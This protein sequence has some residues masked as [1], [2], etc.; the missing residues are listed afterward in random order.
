M[1]CHFQPRDKRSKWPISANLS[2]FERTKKLI[3]RGHILHGL[4]AIDLE[5]EG[6]KRDTVHLKNICISA[7]VH[8]STSTCPPCSVDINK[9]TY[10][11]HADTYWASSSCSELT[12]RWPCQGARSSGGIWVES[13]EP[14]SYRATLAAFQLRSKVRPQLLSAAFQLKII[15]NPT[16]SKH[17]L[18]VQTLFEHGWQELIYHIFQVFKDTLEMWVY[19]SKLLLIFESFSL[20]LFG[21]VS[22]VFW[23]WLNQAETRGVKS[24]GKTKCDNVS[25]KEKQDITRPHEMCKKCVR[26]V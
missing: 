6:L 1:S 2:S 18:R 20:I 4:Y 15:S 25:H 8:S 14:N 19:E 22:Q 3:G 21:S 10:C 23:S 9:L 7:T 26:N 17:H 13:P 16:C 12:L 24:S 5:F 11:L